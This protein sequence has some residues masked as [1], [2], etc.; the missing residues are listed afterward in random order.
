MDEVNRG[1]ACNCQM[2]DGPVTALSYGIFLCEIF[3]LWYEDFMN[4]DAPDIRMFSNLAQMA[5][6][7]PA[8]ECG[9][10]GCCSG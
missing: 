1:K 3:D 5:A 6:G 8:E 7:Y 2:T 10:N 4:G 9:M